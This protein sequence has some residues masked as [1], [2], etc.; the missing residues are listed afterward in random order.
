[1]GFFDKMGSF[2]KN[3][4]RQ[5]DPK[6]E[7]FYNLA[8]K[9][10]ENANAHMKLAVIYQK[11]GE[12]QKATSEYLLA[13]DIFAKNQF[14]ARAIAIYK[15]LSKRDPYLDQ[16]YLKMAEIYREKGCLA[17][18][19][20][21]YRILAQ[22]YEKLGEKDKAL[23]ILK[24]MDEVD[25][26]KLDLPEEGTNHR[27]PNF[28]SVEAPQ[29]AEATSGV[30]FDLGNALMTAAPLEI[31]APKE[32]SIAESIDGVE[33]IF[34][35]LKEIGG[36][37]IAD[38]HFNYNMGVAYRELGF[39]T[40]AMEQ[41]KIAFKLRQ[42][43]FEALS[44]LGFCY[45]EKG[46]WEDAQQ[47]FE[48]ALGMEKIP[49]EKM[50]SAKYILSLLYQELGRLEEALGLLQEIATA[51]KGFLN[52]QEEVF[53]IADKS[54]SEKLSGLA[55]QIYTEKGIKSKQHKNTGGAQFH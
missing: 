7:D 39:H 33:R 18:A 8:Q 36:P 44:M 27:L 4:R 29:G 35:E 5:P 51:D 52:A 3:G 46:R 6:E 34:K 14:Y 40:E 47:A 43:P 10:P 9:E 12:K 54:G 45:W 11:K 2:L 32:V 55:N 50:L 16:V 38:P 21:Q 48:R 25:P 24:I 26:R 13:A 53:G 1:M 15:Q 23:N 17:D 22:Y 49:Q 42:K 30:F 20:A 37:S 31:G 28:D 19:F 41:F